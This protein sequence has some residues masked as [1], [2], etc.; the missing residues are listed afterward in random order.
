MK[1][2]HI[3]GGGD[4]GGAKTAVISLLQR[5]TQRGEVQVRLISLREGD[6]ADSAIQAGIDTVV[7]PTA[8]LKNDLSKLEKAVEDFKPDILH[9]HGGRA[10][11]YAFLLRHLLN[12]RG[13]YDLP[14]ISTVHS[15]YRLD[16]LGSP[17]KQLVNGSIN[18][19]AL[20]HADYYTCVA[21]RMARTLISRGFDPERCFVIYNGIDYTEIAPKPDRA[22]F[23]AQYGYHWKS[24][25]MVCVLAARLTAVKDIPTLLKAAA[26]AV[27]TAPNLHVV[28]AGDGE[29]RASL[30][31]LVQTLGIAGHVT[32][33][34]W[35]R[36]MKTLFAA[37]DVNVLCSLSETFPYSVSE[38][39]REGCTAVVTNVGGMPEMIEDGVSG[40]IVEPGDWQ[41]LGKRLETLAKDE[42]LRRTFAQRL[43]KRASEN[44]SLDKMAQDQT[45]IYEKVL[46]LWARRNKRDAVVICGAYGKGNAGDNAILAALLRELREID[47]ER[48]ICVLS[49]RP[50][51]M[52]LDHRVRSVY[53]FSFPGIL[54]EFRRAMLYINGGGSLIQDVTSQRSLAFYLWTLSAAKRRGLRVM[55]YGCGIGPLLRKNSERR[56]AKVM[57][58][59]VDSITLRDADSKELLE[60]LGVSRPE[61]RLA[62]DPA[63]TLEPAS[64][65]K[66]AKLCEELGMREDGKY[67]AVCIRPWKDSE[68]LMPSVT[69]A[70]EYAWKKYAW[71]P[72]II[73]IESPRDDAASEELAKSLGCPCIRTEKQYGAEETIGLMSKMEGVLAMRLH[74]LIFAAAAGVPQAGISYDRKVSGFLRSLGSAS[75]CALEDTD[76]KTLK[77]FIDRLA[78]TDRAQTLRNTARLKAMENVNSQTLAGLMQ[79][80]N[81]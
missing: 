32:F 72:V 4:V 37:S 42:K 13:K 12:R 76:A 52:K 40:Y 44:F 29:D 58:A 18:A 81:A 39:I 26:E 28:I 23:W 16:Y 62:A 8:G 61:V 48:S 1:I 65:E 50:E 41:T 43:F 55:M 69:Q 22:E 71:T 74:A 70:C 14:V 19:F 51:Q 46:R 2:L 20:R 79:S 80:E 57:N 59:Y 67:F 33:T 35:I 49:K 60:K 5:L 66:T 75:W 73:P 24:G 25:D 3:I 9:S 15:D 47:P 38:G 53:T 10:N 27:K 11:L 30:E 64:S 54:R 31:S 45:A 56:A 21:D 6:F 68:K 77:G 36:D 7:I 34:G 17:L 63:L 78:Q